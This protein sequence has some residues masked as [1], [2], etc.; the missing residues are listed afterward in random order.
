M[1]CL[2]PNTCVKLFGRAI[3]CLSKIGDELYF[4][5]LKDGLALRTV[6]SSRSAY[7]CFIFNKI[8]F[9]DYEQEC[10]QLQSSNGSEL[11]KCKMTMK[12]CLA[13]FKSLATIEKTVEKCKIE[14]KP[15]DC[16]MVFALYCK[17]GI[18]KTHNLTYQECESLQ[19]VFSKE[20]CPNQI[21][22]QSKVMQE[23]VTNFPTSCAEITLNVSPEKVS[24]KN[25]V[26]DEPDPTKVVHTEMTLVP[27]EFDDFQIGIDTQVTFCLKELRSILA[28]SE[29]VNQPIAIYFEHT[30][31]PIV[32]SMSNDIAYVCDFV[33]AT[34]AETEA[35]ATQQAMN[36]TASTNKSS[37]N[38]NRKSIIQNKSID[39]TN[40][41]PSK[42]YNVPKNQ[43]IPDANIS[44]NR[45]V[46]KQL[47]SD[48]QQGINNTNVE[49]EENCSMEYPANV[50]KNKLKTVVELPSQKSIKPAPSRTISSTKEK[51]LALQK[52]RK[53]TKTHSTVHNSQVVPNHLEVMEQNF[54]N[55]DA[56]ND[57]FFSES[58]PY[59]QEM[60]RSLEKVTSP[61]LTQRGK[62][63]SSLLKTTISE[64]N[65]HD[66]MNENGDDV[67]M[68][69]PPPKKIFRSSFFGSEKITI[70]QKSKETNQG[71][72]NVVLLAA[73][74]DD[75]S[76]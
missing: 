39:H 52:E 75:D 62:L 56:S 54:T 37:V 9:D 8:F 45:D 53:R 60:V 11:L 55:V 18:T 29:F 67:L 21:I 33:M 66:I 30:G 1:K 49:I 42:K 71:K 59:Q 70:S 25:Y 40:T 19:A 31:K 13:I 51:F 76:D 7:A 12:S 17:H 72:E 64:H 58:F 36:T 74:T 15:D 4:E 23:T 63:N 38:A 46:S 6:N 16:R 65:D 47:V 44:R 35:G 57:S 41:T 32:F 2:I 50:T 34:L 20:L 26:D 5:G 73:D 3:H 61:T 27:D 10:D 28:F 68:S 14:F 22:A 69:T 43:Q 48:T 24:I